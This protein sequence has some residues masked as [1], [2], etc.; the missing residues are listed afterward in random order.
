[1]ASRSCIWPYKTLFY[2]ICCTVY[3]VEFEIRDDGYDIR[4]S[5][6]ER[7]KLSL[8]LHYFFYQTIIYTP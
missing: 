4:D 1:M 7:K 5:F 2:T 3:I 6:R 8:A